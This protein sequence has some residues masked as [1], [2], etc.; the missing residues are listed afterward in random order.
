MLS[1]ELE[2]MVSFTNERR[3]VLLQEAAAARL[4]GQQEKGRK[5]Y[6]A[7]QQALRHWWHRMMLVRPA[8]QLPCYPLIES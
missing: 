7:W 3:T 4:I 6:V 2:K 8:E 1:H 5:C